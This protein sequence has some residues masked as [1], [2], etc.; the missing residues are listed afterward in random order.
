VRGVLKVLGVP[1]V[2][3]GAYGALVPKVLWCL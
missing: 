3:L 1:Q 2:L